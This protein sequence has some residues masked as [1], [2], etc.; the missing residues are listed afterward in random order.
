MGE[1]NYTFCLFAK[2]SF[3]E[4]YGRL[5]DVS[6]SFNVYNESPTEKEA[7]FSA[8]RADWKAIGLDIKS[9]IEKYEQSITT[10]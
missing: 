6:G 10:K 8:L 5:L 2:P 1:I 9:A 7:D 3:I 4:G